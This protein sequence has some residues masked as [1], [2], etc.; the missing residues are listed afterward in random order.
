VT[1]DEVLE[2]IT[3][4]GRVVLVGGPETGKS[5]LAHRADPEQRRT[6]CTDELVGVLEW[7]EAS[8]EVATW[9]DEPGPWIIEGVA[10]ARALRKWLR[11][12]PDQRFDAVIVLMSKPFGER[13]K[14]QVAMA[15][16]VVTVWN[17]IGPLLVQRGALVLKHDGT[18]QGNATAA[19]AAPAHEGAAASG[20][21]P[22]SPSC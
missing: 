3:R 1:F 13:S 14:G 11:A 2:A 12:H 20:G 5:L 6:R 8:A 16:G 4:H 9:F 19:P 18:P 22:A 10:T 21:A 17:E 7:S 15:K